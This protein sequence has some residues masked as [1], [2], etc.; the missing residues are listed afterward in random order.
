M[1]KNV[2]VNGDNYTGIK[3]VKLPITGTTNHAE[4]VSVE[5]TKQ[6]TTNGSHDVSEY[7]TVNVNVESGGAVAEGEINITANGTHDV[8]QYA[9][10]KV[11]VP[12]AGAGI[13]ELTAYQQIKV[14]PIL[15]P[16]TEEQG[17]IVTNNPLGVKPKIIIVR[18]ADDSNAMANI[19]FIRSGLFDVSSGGGI[20]H[21]I[22]KANG[23]AG[24]NSMT[25]DGSGNV[26]M[27]FTANEST[28]SL[29][30]YNGNITWDLNTE[31]TVDIYA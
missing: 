4:F 26:N 16:A 19:G 27:K 13:G 2:T 18:C 10:A 21:G 15:V 20:V 5:G 6:I 23:N 11:N 1:S 22:N 3:K 25:D 17:R 14:T 9:T 29:F 28:I 31:Y 8:S 24:Y 7:A 30:H 12:Q